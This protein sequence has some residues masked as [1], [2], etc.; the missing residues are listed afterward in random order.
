MCRDK[1]AFCL[2]RTAT[3]R[4]APAIV[5]FLIYFCDI[6]PLVFFCGFQP[7]VRGEN[8]V[9]FT[10]FSFTLS[11]ICF[12][13]F[14]LFIGC[15]ST[16]VLT[17]SEQSLHLCLLAWEFIFGVRYDLLIL[18]SSHLSTQDYIFFHKTIHFSH[19]HLLFFIALG[20]LPLFWNGLCI[21]IWILHIS[22]W[23]FDTYC[24]VYNFLLFLLF[25]FDLLFSLCHNPRK[26]GG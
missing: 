26:G 19:K 12:L 11:Y 2:G 3:H 22:T 23:L 24:H 17:Y 1:Y 9:T 13:F 20:Y 7:S 25:L 14:C 4:L 8:T 10:H 18:L 21:G 16:G 6:L 5:Y 15:G